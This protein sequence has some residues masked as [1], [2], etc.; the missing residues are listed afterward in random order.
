MSKLDSLLARILLRNGALLIIPPNII[1]LALWGALPAAYQPGIFGKDI[2]GWL[3]LFENIL[4]IFVFSLP[5]ILYFGKKEKGQ[6]L[7]WYLYFGGLVVYL[8]SYLALII[9]PASV[10]SQSLIGFTAPAWS[11]VFLFAGIGLVCL[12]SWLPITWHRV[13]YFLIA[14]IFLIFH[15]GHAGLVYFNMIR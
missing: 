11:T 13:I 8:A 4:R 6:P 10:W 1:S 5:G 15:I 14:S 9:F 12:R 7:G 3:G 2:P